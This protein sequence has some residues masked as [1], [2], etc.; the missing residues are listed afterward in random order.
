MTEGRI[1]QWLKQPG[2]RVEVGE[3]VMVVESDKAD[4]DVESFEAGYLALIQVEE[5]ESADVGATVGIIVESKDDISK[6]GTSAP[7]PAATKAPASS[8]QAQAPT[9]APPTP[10]APKTAASSAAPPKPKLAEIFMPA[11]SSTMTEGKIVEWAKGEGDKV[12]V[13]DMVM[14]VESDKADM[15][16]ESFEEGY[17]AHIS[18]DAGQSCVVGEPVAFL[19]KTEAEIPLVK[20]WATSTSAGASTEKATT[21]EPSTSAT[22][23]AAA[24]AQAAPPVTTTSTPASMPV[25]NEGRIIASPLAKATAKK[26]GIDL[27]YVKGTGPSGRIVE[28]DV[29][30]AKEAQPVQPYTPPVGKIIATPD[31]KKVAKKEKIDLAAVK[32]TGNFGRITAEDVLRAAGKAPVEVGKAPATKSS[33]AKPA[34]APEPSKTTTEI[35]AGAVAMNAMQKAVAQNMTASLT[36]PVFRLTYTI[37]TRALDEL[38]AKLKPKGVTLS[39]LLAKAVAI[40]LSRH[41]I[42][43]ALYSEDTIVYRSEVN[44]AM[45]VALKDGGLITPTL[46]NAD[47]TDLY[48][49]SRNWKDMIQRAM[50]KKLTPKEY[51]GGAFIISNLGMF[52]VDQF[53]AILPPGVPGILAVGA[54]KPVV[55]LQE[56][57]LVGVHKE[58]KVTMTA[59][60][61]IIY[62]ADGAEFLKELTNIIENETTELVM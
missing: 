61:R 25:V 21:S 59:D 41:P 20:A 29:L 31:A 14:V 44:V 16:V 38:Y 57:G 13:G 23:A 39:A 62:G 10:E 19:A 28:T 15:D 42:M 40:A 3:S 43:N 50:D 33:P 9:P 54:S 52:G 34:A 22:T 27:K 12:E 56:N 8:S 58:M 51:S 53:D 6:V 26:E 36:T 37:K 60:H 35:P 11:L 24:E 55:G 4:M 1:V 30:K 49:L 47:K 7:A 17:I 5:G 45:A 2:D 32:G 48:T 18:V 46:M